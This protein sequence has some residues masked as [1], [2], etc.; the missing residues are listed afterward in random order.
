MALDI[1][2]NRPL[3]DSLSPVELEELQLNDEYKTELRAEDVTRILG[4]PRE[5][6][7]SLPHLSS[8]AEIEAHRLLVTYTHEQGDADFTKVGEDGQ[9][10]HM[11]DVVYSHG[12]SGG[13]EGLCRVESSAPKQKKRKLVLFETI[14]DVG[15]QERYCVSHGE[16]VVRIA[17]RRIYSSTTGLLKPQESGIHQFSIVD[18]DPVYSTDL[19]V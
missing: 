17:E 8:P 10:M 1:L 13:G 4:L 16:P 5:I 6:Q 18:M 15:I 11:S 2:V 7:L 14:S 12:C 9:D 3:Y 19:K